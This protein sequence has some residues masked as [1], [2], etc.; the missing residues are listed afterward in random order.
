MVNVV[1]L[2][3]SLSIFIVISILYNNNFDIVSPSPKP[4]TFT[5]LVLS[6]CQKALNTFFMSSCEI[7]IPLSCIV[8]IILFLQI[9]AL[10]SIRLLVNLNA[11]ES[12]WFIILFHASMLRLATTFFLISSMNTISTSRKELFALKVLTIWLVKSIMGV[13]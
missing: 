7:P 5:L 12:K 6:Q 11:F 9:F 10:T 2:F 4:D 8:M 13:G 1:N 3:T